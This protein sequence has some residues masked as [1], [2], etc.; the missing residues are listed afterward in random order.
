[1]T[2]ARNGTLNLLLLRSGEQEL[3]DLLDKVRT[4]LRSLMTLEKKDFTLDSLKTLSTSM[5]RLDYLLTD[6]KVFVDESISALRALGLAKLANEVLQLSPLLEQTTEGIR[7]LLLIVD[8]ALPEKR[9]L[10]LVAQE[11]RKV[12]ELID[13]Y[14]VIQ[15]HVTGLLTPLC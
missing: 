4:D 15:E 14:I 3:V 13:S 10:D 2:P 6:V 8:L 9:G 5:N 7:T 1:M 11:A 12:N